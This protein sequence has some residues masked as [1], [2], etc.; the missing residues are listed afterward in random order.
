MQIFKI[1]LYAILGAVMKKINQ[2]KSPN[3]PKRAQA[4][5]YSI[6]APY[7]YKIFRVILSLKVEY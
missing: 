1:K 2:N 4:Y 5:T 6:C 3:H 7:N